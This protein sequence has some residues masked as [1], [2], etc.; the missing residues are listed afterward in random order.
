MSQNIVEFCRNII[1]KNEMKRYILNVKIYSQWTGKG[2][3]LW[4][5]IREMILQK[6]QRI[7]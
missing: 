7:Y 5:T 6:L 4:R 1:I 3:C 2:V